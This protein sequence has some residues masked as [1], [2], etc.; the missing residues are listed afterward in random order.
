MSTSNGNT[1]SIE[2]NPIH[3]QHQINIESTSHNQASQSSP[4]NLPRLDLL[5]G[6]RDDFNTICVP[7]YNASTIGDLEAAKVILD[8]RRELVRFSI[9]ES[10]ET[11][12]HIAVLSKSYKFVEY[13]MSLMT[14][15]DIKLSNRNGETAFYLVA[16]VGNVKMAHILVKK[17][18]GVINITDSQGR[19]PLHVA[20][21]FGRRTMV[22]YLY[23]DSDKM[24]GGFWTHQNRS[25]VLEACVENWLYG[26]ESLAQDR[27]HV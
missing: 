3:Q 15:E 6:E 4:L 9:I 23:D 13:L 18:R 11:M 10:Y 24:S 21:L 16:R 5:N 12:L 2:L 17:N 20:A 19:M 22:Q 1:D 26:Q 27:K 14:E 7:L 25:W 8:K